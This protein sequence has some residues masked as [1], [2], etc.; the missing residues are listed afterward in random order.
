MT[1]EKSRSLRRV[2]WHSCTCGKRGYNTRADAKRM[3]KIQI[4]YGN[5]D[6]GLPNA[7]LSTYRCHIDPTMFHIGHATEWLRRARREG[8]AP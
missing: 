8:D 5:D 6:P 2:P 7:K 3:L 4:G 1:G